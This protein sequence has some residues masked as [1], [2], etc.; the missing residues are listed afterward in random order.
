MKLNTR[1]FGEINI[2]ESKI[3]VFEEGL[4]GFEDL[5]RFALFH[6]ESEARNPEDSDA[7]EISAGGVFLW[8]QSI[9]DGE[10]AFVLLNTFLFMPNY[11][12]NLEEGALDSIGECDPDDLIIRNI[13]VIP[14]KLENMTVNLCAPVVINAAT[15]KGKQVMV[16]NKEYHVRHRIIQEAREAM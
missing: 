16:T 8:L 5:T 14:D 11:N 12:P 6:D 2:D 1:H 4:P 15:L 7:Q 9:D 3:V 10:T 13:A